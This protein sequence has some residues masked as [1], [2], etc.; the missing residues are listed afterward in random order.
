MFTD[1][2]KKELNKK[3]D[4]KHVQPPKSFGPKG[5]YLE[6]WFVIE[7]ANRIFGHDGWSYQIV[8]CECV[9][10][11]ERAIG[12]K[13][14][15]GFGVT[16]T[17]HIRVTVGDVIRE[18]TGAGHGYDRDCGL[19]HESAIKESVTDALKRALRTFG[20]PFGLALYDK[21]RANVGVEPEDQKAKSEAKWLSERKPG[22]RLNEQDGKTLL[23]TLRLGLKNCED[24]ADLSTFAGG[25]A[26]EIA[27]LPDAQYVAFKWSYLD[28][29]QR[30]KK[31]A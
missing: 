20:N 3:L 21:S 28:A 17:T 6:G 24:D 19:A 31:A 5:D 8:R 30:F 18:D 14:E 22:P 9:F 16:Y 13:K 23:A 10:Q 11:G 29:L 15:P 1:E 7:E 4:P 12:Q 26:A 25:N 27:T 2:Q